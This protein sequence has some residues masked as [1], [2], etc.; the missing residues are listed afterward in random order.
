MQKIIPH[1]WF[2]R[3]AKEAA[4]FY[5]TLFPDSKVTNLTKLHN[6]PSGD[7]D[8]VSFELSGQS[9]MAISAGP[10][11]RFNPSISFFVN[12]DPSK[13]RNA[14]ENLKRLWEKLISGGV[15]L[16]PLQQYP[17]SDLYGWVQDRY[18]LSWQLILSNPQGEER[19]NLV[20]SLLFV[21]KVSGRAE[22]AFS[23]YM[24]VFRNSRMGIVARYGKGREPDREGTVMY[25]DFMIENQW[26]AAMDSAYNHDFS[27]NEAISF[28]VNCSTQ[29]EIDYYWE[30]LSAV[31]EAEQCGWLKD[32]YGLSWQ[33]VPAVMNE[34]MKNG[35]REQIDRLTQAFLPMKK[36]D[37]EKLKEAYRREN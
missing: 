30:R 19:P 2:D 28:M 34:M 33:I 12:F 22:E 11:F 23:F 20:P 36:I 24:S 21:G 3:E 37:I 35:S 17:F 26:F 18:G 25:G 29:E 6:T 16:M 27:F 4:D 1:L 8:I 15:A 32:R 13:D 7:A 10:V 5:C 31:P 14:A 9:F